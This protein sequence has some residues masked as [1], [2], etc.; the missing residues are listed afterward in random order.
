MFWILGA[1]AKLNQVRAKGFFWKPPFNPLLAEVEWKNPDLSG[2]L[3]YFNF[4]RRVTAAL[5]WCAFQTN[6][7]G[8]QAF[9]TQNVVEGAFN[10]VTLEVLQLKLWLELLDKSLG[11]GKKFPCVALVLYKYVGAIKVLQ[12]KIWNWKISNSFDKVDVEGNWES[13]SLGKGN[14]VKVTRLTLKNFY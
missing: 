7:G 14:N 8:M 12:S 9:Q 1:S 5:S 2:I 6:F 3:F 4:L 11:C 13:Q 10:W